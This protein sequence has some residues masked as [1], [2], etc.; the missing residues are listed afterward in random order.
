MKKYLLIGLFL[1]LFL[2][3]ASLEVK[4]FPVNATL[5]TSY[6]YIELS[7]KLADGIFFTNL[8]GSILNK[9]FPLTA[10]TSNNNATWNYDNSDPNKASGYWFFIGGNY[11]VDVCHKTKTNLC[12]NF[13]CSGI[14]N[15]EIGIGNVSWSISE[16][17]DKENPSLIDS[18]R[19][20]LSWEKIVEN[21]INKKYCLRYWLNVPPGTPARNYSTKYLI[22]IVPKGKP[23]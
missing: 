14:N 7:D 18:K 20:K 5:A 15:T 23:C 4:E 8:T 11:P 1:A 22:E 16:I 10:G 19:M 13:N 12:S 3:N 9:Q 21:A 6:Y 2:I 17:C